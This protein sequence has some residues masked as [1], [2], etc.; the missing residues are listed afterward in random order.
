MHRSGTS[1]TAAW[2]QE[3]GVII[4]DGKLIGPAEGNIRGHFE[5]KEFVDLHSEVILCKNETSRGWVECSNNYRFAENHKKEINHLIKKRDKYSIWGWKDPRSVLF[6][7]EWV[8]LIPDL[9]FIFVWRPASE[10]VSSLI[11]RKQN[12]SNP[13]F[14]ISRVD[15]YNTWKHYNIQIIKFL[16][17]Y[18]QRSM[19]ININ[20]M[21]KVDRFFFNQFCEKYDLNLNYISIQELVDEKLLN[22]KSK[23]LKD[24]FYYKTLGLSK[25]EKKLEKI[26]E[27][28][29][30]EK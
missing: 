6:L 27:Y 2:L 29:V 25:I 14:K 8:R 4:D 21:M 18:P 28:N 5:D 10:V 22:P 30:E 20:K 16:Q 15:G 9:K 3:C 11:K 23:N 19:L 13:D 7:E 26:S 24:R 17:K 1:L 12:S